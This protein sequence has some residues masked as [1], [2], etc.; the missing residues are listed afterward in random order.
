MGS[1]R[2]RLVPAVLAGT[3]SWAVTVLPAA[4]SPG[5]SLLSS[6]AAGVGLLALLVSPM[7]PQGRWSM[8][9]ALDLFVGASILSWWGARNAEF[10]LPFGVFGS[11]GWLAYTLALGALS[12]PPRLPEATDPGPEL[13]PRTPPSK[14]AVVVLGVVVLSSLALLAAAWRVERP[15]LAVLAHI[16]ALSVILLSLRTAALMAVHFQVRGTRIAAPLRLKN[17]WLPLILFFVAVGT[18]GFLRLR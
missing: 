4:S 1:R 9:T 8:I 6:V 16:I 11:F 13:H 2:S 7:L 14:A 10:A 15:G 3:Y 17:A 18:A 12:T 5:A